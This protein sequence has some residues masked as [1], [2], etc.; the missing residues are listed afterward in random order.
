MEGDSGFD[1][2]I[3]PTKQKHVQGTLL[4]HPGAFSTLISPAVLYYFL[5]S[6]NCSLRRTLLGRGVV[7]RVAVQPVVTSYSCLLL[8]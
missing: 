5:D 1:I 7:S 3:V 2:F 6:R 8:V 4:L